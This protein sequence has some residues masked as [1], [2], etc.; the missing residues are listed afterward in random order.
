[1]W[2]NVEIEKGDVV[3]SIIMAVLHLVL[4]IIALKLE[5]IAVS[6]QFLPYLVVCFN[7]R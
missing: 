2:E 5:A 7:A 3:S 4:E 6:S 1:M